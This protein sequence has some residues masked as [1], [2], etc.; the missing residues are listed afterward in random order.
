MT[1]IEEHMANISDEQLRINIRESKQDLSD[2][3]ADCP[4]SEWHQ[5]CFAALVLYAQEAAKRGIT[6]TVKSH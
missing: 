1:V 6:E 4:E 2:A 5:S 3:A